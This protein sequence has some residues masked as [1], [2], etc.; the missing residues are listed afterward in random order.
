MDNVRK[1]ITPTALWSD[2]NDSLP[3]KESK[4]NEMI[5]DG[6]IYSEV[7]FS[8][9]ETESGRV[10]IYGLYARPQNLPSGRKIGGGLILT[11]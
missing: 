5:Y 4:V 6:I 9:R 11:D 1:I 2:F 7:Y 10:R 8:G 3:L